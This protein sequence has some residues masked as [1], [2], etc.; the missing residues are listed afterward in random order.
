[1]SEFSAWGTQLQIG[2]GGGP[3]VFTTIA[4]VRDIGGP[5]LSLDALDVT[6]HDS[7]D[8]W[9][10]FIGG[11]KDGGEVSLELVW[12]PDSITQ[13]A[14][15]DDLDTRVV[16][17]F[18]IIF[19]DLTSTTWSLAAMVTEFEPGANVED[20]LTASVTLKVSGEPTLA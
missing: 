10:E 4:Q 20:E 7:P 9:R 12:D 19:P 11:L 5:G 1:M 8:A 16:R 14:M 18:K 17:N 6:T 2:D 15:R 3:E 13:S